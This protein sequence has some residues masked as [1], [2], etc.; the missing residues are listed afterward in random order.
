M[1]QICSKTG[2]GVGAPPLEALDPDELTTAQAAKLM[3]EELEA[4][5]AA[6]LLEGSDNLLVRPT[7]QPFG[8]TTAIKPPRKVG[9]LPFYYVKILFLQIFKQRKHNIIIRWLPEL[10]LTKWMLVMK[11]FWID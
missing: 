9:S 1:Q 7:Q 5:E 6:K 8:V 11:P 3:A 4:E 10:L 2:G